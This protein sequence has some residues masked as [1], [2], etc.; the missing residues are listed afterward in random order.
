MF[1]DIYNRPPIHRKWLLYTK[2]DDG[3]VSVMVR[4]RR[5]AWRCRRFPAGQLHQ[6]ATVTDNWREISCNV[7]PVH[8]LS[9][10]NVN[11][12]CTV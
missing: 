5:R 6:Q 10:R 8:R 2:K 12:C 1:N 4:R 11:V 3:V 7:L 9:L